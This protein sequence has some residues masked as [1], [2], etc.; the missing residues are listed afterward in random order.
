MGSG[1][2][3]EKLTIQEVGFSS[4]TFLGRFG[5]DT[6]VGRVVGADTGVETLEATEL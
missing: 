6:L 5:K 2:V 1:L 4:A 3:P